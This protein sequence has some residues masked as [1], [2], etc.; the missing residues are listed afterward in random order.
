MS[1]KINGEVLPEA[2][3]EFELSR[4]VRF[5][6]EHMNE[7][8]LRAQMEQF[9]SKA[10]MQAIGAKLLIIEAS[11]LDLKV[12]DTYVDEKLSVMKKECG[13]EETFSKMLKEQEATVEMVR[14][15]ISDGHR[16][17]MLVEKVT[18]EAS[19]PT[20]AEMKAHFE[21]HAD[22]YKKPERAQAQHILVK[23][24]SDS[25]EDK[26]AAAKCLE[27][28]KERLKAGADFAEEAGTHSECPSGKSAGGSLGWFS[29]GMM[30]PAFDEVVFDM[31]VGTVSDIIETDFGVHIINKTGHEQPESAS[32]DEVSDNIKD[33]LRHVKRGEILSSYVDD[34]KKKA[35]IE[36]D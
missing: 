1:I 4:I 20:E 8:E 29:R 17:D 28:I 36:E 10:R 24:K 7:T 5:Y 25:G 13:G 18:T 23:P 33:F 19:E 3:I 21:A 22:E 31:E 26:E 32:Y 16:V 2:A 27:D 14:T 12:P 15:N 34:L 9:K 11:R 6:A 30:V 35:N